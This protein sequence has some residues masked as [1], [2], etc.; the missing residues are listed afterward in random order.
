MAEW[1]GTSFSSPLV[2]GLIATRISRTGD[3]GWDAAQEAIAMADSQVINGV[4]PALF[5]GDEF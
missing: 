2:A 4:G 3:S 5:P 1:S